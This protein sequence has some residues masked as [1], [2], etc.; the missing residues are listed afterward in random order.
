MKIQL[1]SW[2]IGMLGAAT[3]FCGVVA[4]AGAVRTVHAFA[5]Y[6]G[7]GAAPHGTV[8]IS[9]ST[10]YGM[11]REG[12]PGSNGV[13]YKV[14]SDGTGYALLH[15]FPAFPGDG[16]RP[17]GSLTLSGSLLFGTTYEGGAAGKGTIFKMRTDGGGLTVLRSF[18][19][20]PSDGEGPQGSLTLSGSSLYGMTWFGGAYNGG[21][22]FKSGTNGTGFTL[23]HSFTNHPTDGLYPEGSLAISGSTLFGMTDWG[24]AG[25]Q[26]T[27]FKLNTS[28]GGFGLLHSFAGGTTD[29]AWPRGSLTLSGSTLYGMT[30]NGGSAN[31]GTAFKMNTNGSSFNVLH[32]FTGA[33]TDGGYPAGSLTLSGP[34]LYGVT[35]VGGTGYVGTVFSLQTDGTGFGVLHSFTTADGSGP[36]GSLASSG[37]AMFGTTELGGS[38]DAG[39]VFAL[40]L[41]LWAGATDVGGGWS[42]LPWFGYFQDVGGGWIWHGQLGWMFPNGSSTASIWLWYQHASLWLWTSDSAY[43]FLWS[44]SHNAWLWYYEGTGNGNGGWF[45]NYGTGQ[46]QWL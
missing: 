46:V 12:G 22:V 20:A 14:N 24:G 9:G 18:S 25:G 35:S 6:P 41:G 1:R 16:A 39:L 15:T 29:G 19:G 33:A 36:L 42:Y 5:G 38:S 7:D 26:G 30:Y 44:S 11:T 17:A 21:A 10:L 40:P 2:A 13:I 34:T 27:V 3:L 37:T 43:P 23:L 8:A 4:Q 28:G 31:Q 45:Y 32:S